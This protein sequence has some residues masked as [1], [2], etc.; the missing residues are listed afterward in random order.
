MLLLLHPF[1]QPVGPGPADGGSPLRLGARLPAPDSPYRQV[2][3]YEKHRPEKLSSGSRTKEATSAAPR[4]K[5]THRVDNQTD[6]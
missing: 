3:A 1:I 2:R 5:E 4:I 6:G